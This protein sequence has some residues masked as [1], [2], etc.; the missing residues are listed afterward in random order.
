M[1]E[2][3]PADRVIAAAG[4]GDLAA[5]RALV[6]ADGALVSAATPAGERAIHAAHYHGHAGVVAYLVAHG[7]VEDIWL[8]TQLGRIER[9]QAHLDA[10]PTLIASPHPTGVIPLHAAVFWGFPDIVRLM[11]ERGADVTHAS[12]YGYTPLHSAVAAPTTYCPGEEED[13]VLETVQLLLDAGGD[14]NARTQGGQTPAF[15]AAANGDLR[16]VQVLVAHG[17]DPSIRSYAG[18]GPYADRAP[19]DIAAERGHKHV[20]AYL[21]GL[22]SGS[23][24]AR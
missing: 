9:V 11:L 2:M 5:V 10:D 22:A 18:D 23:P 17:A 13:V 21:R 24:A 14:P 4:A 8:D 6:E 7:E 16:V 1:A 12:S 3:T 15:T 20:V 19:V